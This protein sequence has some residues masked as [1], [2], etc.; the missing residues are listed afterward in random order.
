MA[1]YNNV[2]VKFKQRYGLMNL[3]NWLITGEPQID[4]P[5]F[6]IH[7]AYKEVEFYYREFLEGCGRSDTIIAVS[8]NNY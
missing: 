7:D 2:D 1:G 8:R 3:S 4:K 5:V 6:E